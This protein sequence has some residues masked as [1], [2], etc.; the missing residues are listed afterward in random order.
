MNSILVQQTS[1]V[2]LTSDEV[3]EELP[4]L[5][6]KKSNDDHEDNNNNF[7]FETTISS[8]SSA[9]VF[10]QVTTKPTKAP[11][12]PKVSKVLVKD[13]PHVLIWVCH[14]GLGQSRCWSKKSLKIVG[15]YGSKLE[16]E[17]KKE[18]V[19]SRYEN[20]G[21]GDILTGGTWEDEIDLVIRPA[22]ECTL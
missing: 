18:Q 8:P 1:V 17:T 2:D 21:H 14:N 16:A 15:V 12:A 9:D 11:K 13:Q 20:C 10:K 4:S 7:R 3:S 6:R 5:K 19:M 22:E